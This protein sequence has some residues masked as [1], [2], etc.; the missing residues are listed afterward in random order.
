MQSVMKQQILL[1]AHYFCTN[2][3]YCLTFQSKKFHHCSVFSIVRNTKIRRNQMACK[4][5]MKWNSHIKEK[6]WN[7][8][9]ILYSLLPVSLS[10][11][12]NQLLGIGKSFCYSFWNSK[13]IQFGLWRKCCWDI[14]YFIPWMIIIKTTFIS[15]NKMAHLPIRI[16]VINERIYNCSNWI[17]RPYLFSQRFTF[18]QLLMNNI[19]CD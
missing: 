10:A 17:R 14:Q 1:V 19:I 9:R 6:Y 11:L 18:S 12:F 5:R 8:V 16:F 2:F 4:Q 3:C 15:A 13:N 7:G